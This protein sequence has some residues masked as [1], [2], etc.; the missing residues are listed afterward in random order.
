MSKDSRAKSKKLSVIRFLSVSRSGSSSISK[1]E[2]FLITVCREGC[3]LS[4]IVFE[5]DLIE[6]D[7]WIVSGRVV[8]IGGATVISGISGCDTRVALRPRRGGGGR[9]IIPALGVG[10]GLITGLRAFTVGNGSTGSKLGMFLS[11]KKLDRVGLP[12]WLGRSRRIGDS[13]TDIW[14]LEALLSGGGEI[15]TGARLSTSSAILKSE[16]TVDADRIE[17]PRGRDPEGCSGM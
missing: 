1:K 6:D 12:G 16:N 4:T 10:D 11:S 5:F 17:N 7:L 3:A 8:A 9:L 14:L 2:G 13:W 15:V